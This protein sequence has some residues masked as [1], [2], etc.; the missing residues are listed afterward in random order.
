MKKN[1]DAIFVDRDGVLNYDSGY[2]FKF[3]KDLIFHD[4]IAFLRQYSLRK[5]PIIII[6]LTILNTLI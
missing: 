6:T 1:I 5:I 4:S 3:N 2:S